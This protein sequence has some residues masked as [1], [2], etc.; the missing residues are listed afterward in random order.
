M[1]ATAV[2]EIQLSFAPDRAMLRDFLQRHQLELEGDVDCAFGIFS[3]EGTLLGCGCAAGNILKCFAIEDTLRGQGG[4]GA[5]ISRLNADRMAAGHDGL[6]VLTRPHNKALF[7]NC[8]FYP[9][10]QT[11]Q[12]LLLENRRDGVERFLRQVPKAPAQAADV[13]AIVMNC[14]PLTNGHLALIRHAAQNCD[15]LY[16]FVVEEN[17]SA[18]PFSDRLA[19]VRQAAAGMGQVCVCPSGAYVISSMTFP[20]Y[21]LK[22]T[23]DPSLLQSELDITLFGSLIAPALRISKRFAGQ[24]PLDPTTDLYNRTMERLLPRF[25]VAFH[26]IPRTSLDGVPI[27]AS[28]VRRLLEENGGVTAELLRLVPDCTGAYLEKIYGGAEK[29]KT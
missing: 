10:V 5:L 23:E 21:F 3:H 7:S 22:E 18:F 24:E 14:N 27:S 20:V 12:V 6:F 15:F 8:G 4:L 19:L 2:R 16:L 13:G 29:W 17:R 26:E 9:V 11:D 25:G 28:R 1:D